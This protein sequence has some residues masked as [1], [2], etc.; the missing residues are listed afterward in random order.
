M[1]SYWRIKLIGDT[2]KRKRTAINLTRLRKNIHAVMPMRTTDKTLILGTWNIRNFDNN[3]FKHGP[4]IEESYF[5]LAEM[6]HAFDVIAI[7][8]I[9]RNL[10][11]L[12]K[13]MKTLGSNYEYIITDTT[14]GPSGNE[15]RLGFIYNKR[16]VSF[17]GVAGEVVLPD[18]KE[19]RDLEKN[20]QFARTP[21]CC[22]FQ[23]GWFKFMF[24]TVHIYY[25]AA[26]KNTPQFK[27]RV[28]EIGTIA[29]FLAQ[30]AGKD[31][32]NYVLVG[33]FNITNYEDE[34]YSGLDDHGFTVFKNKQGSNRDQTKFYDQISF[35]PREGE[36]RLGDSSNPHGVF[37]IFDSVFTDAQFKDYEPSVFATLKR[38]K[39]ALNAKLTKAKTD[40]K[41]ASLNKQITAIVELENNKA[42]RRNYYKKEW[43]TFQMSDHLPLWV[44]LGIDFADDYLQTMRTS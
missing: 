33:D 16:K 23:S 34:T 37:D 24:A 35:K 39:S 15:E 31:E 32:Y 44:E 21:Y 26:G 13:L 40:S 7:Q 30:R 2:I 19:I 22:A 28:K 25:G 4:R 17:Q 14:E 36:L 38:R 1:P 18:N 43:R 41:K 42:K 5:Y 27:R 29:K 8:E 3:R 9:N 20:R 10:R 12:K 11:P 6:I